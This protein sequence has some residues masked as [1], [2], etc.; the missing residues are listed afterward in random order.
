MKFKMEFEVAE[1]KASRCHCCGNAGWTGHGFVYRNG[2]AYAVYYCAWSQAHPERGVSLAIAV[3]EW[4]DNSS[5]RDRTCV[6]VEA[7]EGETEVLF[8]V[9]D[10]TESPWPQTD[11]LGLMLSREEALKSAII[12]DIFAIAESIARKHPALSQFLH[13]C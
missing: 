12:V 8:R 10:P 7:Y 1:D 3:G 9:L 2:D 11:L 13:I 5:V 6:G 4:D